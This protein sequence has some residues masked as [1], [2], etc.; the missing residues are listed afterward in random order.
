VP[1]IGNDESGGPVDGQGMCQNYAPDMSLTRGGKNWWRLE[2]VGLLAFFGVNLLMGINRRPNHRL[3]WK[4]TDPAVYCAF[5]S[6][7]MSRRRYED[8]TRCIHIP[9]DKIEQERRVRGGYDVD[10]VGKVRWL[11]TEIRKQC[12]AHWNLHQMITVNELMVGYKGKYCPIRQYLPKKP[13]KWGIKIWCLANASTKYVYTWDVY[14]GSDLKGTMRSSS[15]GEAKT[16]YAIVMKLVDELHHRGHVVLTDNFFTSPKLLVDMAAKGTFGTGTVR[17][18]RIGL[19]SRL[20]NTKLWTKE[21]Q[22]TIGWRMH[23]SNKISSVVWCDKKP[24]LI[25]STHATPIV[26]VGSTPVTV[27]RR[28]AGVVLQVPTSPVHKEYTTWMRGVDVADQIRSSY[29]SQVRSHK[30]WHR[31]LFFLLDTTVGNCHVLHKELCQ[32]LGHRP[33]DHMSFQEGLAKEICEP[34]W[35]RRGCVSQWNLAT[36][37]LHMLVKTNK[38][39]VCKYCGQKP[40]ARYQCVACGG[41]FLHHGN[42][43]SKTHYPL[44]R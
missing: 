16:R 36:P 22:G 25:L 15:P 41:A 4:N 29:S 2:V 6:S 14:T 32:K 39:R 19:P 20:A 34:W 23:S 42:C 44:R 33:Q 11:M 31:L 30:W 8:I 38:R 26:P 40:R 3:Y 12:I 7:I 1:V 10:K 43:Y 5:I 18:N 35:V 28:N 13:T 27:P 21:V 17:T 37:A 24:V 9:V